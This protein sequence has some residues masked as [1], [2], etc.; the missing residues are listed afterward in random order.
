[1]KKTLIVDVGHQKASLWEG[2][3]LKGVF[4]ISTA[5]RGLGS[6]PNSG[7]TP[8]G[9]LRVAE[10]FGEGMPLGTIFKDRVAVGQWDGRD[11]EGRDM[12]LSRILWLEGMEPTNQTTHDRYIY[13]H[14]TSHESKLGTPNSEGCIVFANKDIVKVFDALEVGDTVKV[15]APRI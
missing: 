3:T 5:K 11:I 9:T 2:H 6:T 1:M 10:K 15:L 14:G 8:T 13:L 4:T 7:C 12:I